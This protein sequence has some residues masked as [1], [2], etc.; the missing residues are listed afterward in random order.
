MP[1]AAA[2]TTTALAGL[3]DSVDEVEERG[4]DALRVV[5]AKCV[6]GELAGLPRGEIRS[7]CTEVAARDDGVH[8]A[9]AEAA[10]QLVDNADRV[11]SRFV[12]GCRGKNCEV[13]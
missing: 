5:F 10:V 8:P 1:E 4:A 9:A 12:E 2:V 13:D 3:T 11:A 7:L 6:S